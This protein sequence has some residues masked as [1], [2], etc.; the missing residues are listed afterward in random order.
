MAS[1]K[2]TAHD[3]SMF[4][5]IAGSAFIKFIFNTKPLMLVHSNYDSPEVDKQTNTQDNRDNNIEFD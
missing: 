5:C 4:I 2:T 3:S 1:A